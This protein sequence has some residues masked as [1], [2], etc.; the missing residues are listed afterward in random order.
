[1]ANF[2]PNTYNRPHW[3]GANSDVD[4]HIEEHLGFVDASFTYSSKLA[5]M[6]NTRSLRGTNVQRIDRIGAQTVLGRRATEDLT[7]SKVV[8]D[9]LN[10]VV[11]TVL[12]TRNPFDN[13]DLWTSDLDM[14]KELGTEAGIALA[15]LYDQS[16]LIAAAKCA[17]FVVPTGLDTAFSPG[18]L[19]P[20]TVDGTPSTVAEGEAAAASLVRAHRTS[21]A[22]LIKRDLGDDLY[23]T[24]VTFVSPLVF[25]ILLEHAKLLNVDYQSAGPSNDFSRARIGHLNGV[26]VV[27]TPRIPT[28]AISNH[29]LGSA[30]NVSA[31]EARRQMIT[32]IPSKTLVCAE[33]QPVTAKFWENNEDFGWVLDT[34]TAYT[35]AARRPDSAAVVDITFT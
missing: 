31:A 9:K 32:I 22:E 28:A 16:A 20:A 12:Y 3:G 27:E 18:I 5:Q 17:D 6:L 33:V 23:S 7:P 30:F 11:D 13:F 8:N 2:A 4:I 24:G 25:S 34:Y 35:I 21:V 26:K 15:K 19:I 1:M 14:R 10:I 29:A